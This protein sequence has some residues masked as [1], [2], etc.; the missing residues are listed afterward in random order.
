[1]AETN[2]PSCSV[3]GFKRHLRHFL[4]K[5]DMEISSGLKFPPSKRGIPNG[6]YRVSLQKYLAPVGWHLS[7]AKICE[8]LNQTVR[9]QNG[10]AVGDC[11]K[12]WTDILG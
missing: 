4:L 8:I 12:W 9:A 6:V 2:S 1:M 11:M 5:I 7:D 3:L 10:A